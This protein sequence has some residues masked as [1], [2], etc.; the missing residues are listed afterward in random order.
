MNLSRLALT[1]FIALALVAAGCSKSSPT[2]DLA[3]QKVQE[4]Y[5]GDLKQVDSIEIRSGSTG[6]LKTYSDREQIQQWLSSIANIVITPEADQEGSVGTLFSVYLFEN[7]QLRLTFTNNSIR[8]VY[9]V[10]NNEL[11][12][13]IKSLFEDAGS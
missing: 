2:P 7:K 8:N 11:L 10:S 9:Y 6:E 3:P 13:A 4:L 5:P 1:L 12:E